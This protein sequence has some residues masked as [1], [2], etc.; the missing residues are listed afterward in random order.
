MS[1]AN[2]TPVHRP[3]LAPGSSGVSTPSLLDRIGNTPLLRL[4]TLTRELPFVQLF[5]KAEWHNPGGS[6]K[7]RTAASIVAGAGT[8]D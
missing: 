7:D 8:T 2:S 6:I 3:Q 1:V 5:G 4:E